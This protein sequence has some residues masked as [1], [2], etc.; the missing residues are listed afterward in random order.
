M[1][2]LTRAII[3]VKGGLTV[4]PKGGNVTVLRKGNDGKV[5][6]VK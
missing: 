1:P 3:A 6:E 5:T 2:D 4:K